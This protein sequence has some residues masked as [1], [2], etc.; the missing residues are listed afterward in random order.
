MEVY[1]QIGDK[2]RRMAVSRLIIGKEE[3]H[4]CVVEIRGGVVERYY[5]FT[6]EQPFTEWLGGVMTL[7]HDASG[8]LVVIGFEDSN[9]MY[10]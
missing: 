1:A 2:L 5:S 8:N 7:G 9:V 6:A 4:Q 3:M 10:W